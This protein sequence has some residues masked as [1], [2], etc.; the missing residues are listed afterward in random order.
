MS[1]VILIVDDDLDYLAQMRLQLEAAGYRVVTQ[2]SAAAARQWLTGNRP[3]LVLADLMLEEPDA[4]F[5][6]CYQVKRRD[7][8]IPV[9]IVTAVASTTG[10]T[11]DAE[12]DEERA[13][14]K[15]DAL[16][17]KPVRFEQLQRELQRL[18]AAPAA[19][20]APAEG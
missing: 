12:T 15:A 11:F 6:L 13:W 2:E 20:G 8:T 17:A 4:G 5:S 10:L 14:I 1:H 9:V 7:P 18:L 19:H 3:D 16:L